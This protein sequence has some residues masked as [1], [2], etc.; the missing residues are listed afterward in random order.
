MQLCRYLGAEVYATC[1]DSKRAYLSALGIKHIYNS[2]T[3]DFEKALLQDTNNQGVDVVLN[4]LT[5][6]GFIDASIKCLKKGGVFLEIG[7]RNIYTKEQM[8]PDIDYHII[9]LDTLA[10]E[11]PEQVGAML[12]TITT[13]IN[14]KQLKP[15]PI[16]CFD[17][18]HSILAFEKLQHAKNIGKLV[19]TE[20]APLTPDAHIL[21]TGGLG[22]LGGLLTH[23]LHEQGVAH[24]S[25]VSRSKPEQPQAGINY[26]QADIADKKQVHNIIS[27]AHKKQPLTGIFH[28]AGVLDD[29]IFAEQ[30][31][32]R[33]EQ[34]FHAKV[35]GALNLHEATKDIPLDY[36]VLFSSIASSMGS[37]GQ[38]NYAAANSFLDQ[39][40]ITRHQQG[41]PALSIQW[42]PWLE[43]GMAKN[44]VAEHARKGMKA[45]TTQQGLNALNSALKTSLPVIQVADI[46]WKAIAKQG[47]L[48]SWM[49]LM[50]KDFKVAA[51]G[52]LVSLLLQ[53]DKTE[54]QAVLLSELKRIIEETLGT[55]DIAADK[56]FFDIGMDSLMAVDARNRIQQALGTEYPVSNTLLFE[57]TNLT[58]LEE[59]LQQSILFAV[60]EQ[61]KKA[62]PQAMQQGI[63]SNEPIAIIGMDCRFPGGANTAEQF[64][65]LL[66]KSYEGISEVPKDRWDIDQYYD[67]DPE[68]PGKMNTRMGGFLSEDVSLF[69]AAFFNISP[70]EAQMMDPQQR[71]L[72]ETAWHALENAGIEPDSLRGSQTGVYLGISTQDYAKLEERNQTENEINAYMGTGNALSV[73]AGRIAFTLGLQ[74]PAM[75]IETAC[76]SSLV[77]LHLALQGLRANEANMALV[78]GVNLLLSPDLSINFTKAHMLSA[79]GHCKTFDA[80]ADGY[81]R[82]EGCGVVVLKRLSDAM[83]DEDRILALIKGSAINQD[84]ASSG[85]TVPNGSAQ[86]AV[87]QQ[88]LANAQVDP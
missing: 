41:L 39:L 19:I 62:K 3:T 9:A 53:V 29:G 58:A 59:H 1:S 32:E 31:A 51:S 74:G 63:A 44:L 72:L 23:W 24:I 28:L 38:T 79:D 47:T 14:K 15:L 69:D 66:A 65:E 35:Q 87:M 20:A 33:F 84:G 82:G 21:I 61:E 49:H 8:R 4:S 50:A 85:L 77:A 56:G 48:A 60:F 40:A 43:A 18:E 36:F 54:R 76:S 5:S 7:K 37:P 75:S 78:A 22:A 17:L 52:Q 16:E 80:S 67:P 86:T 12:A 10:Q 83:R 30:N 27:K 6:E 11:H 2:R 70:K 55:K 68:A 46:N 42:G 25:I 71:L 13:R 64:W 73:A 45:L 81:G 34:V 26:Y 88:A 57:H